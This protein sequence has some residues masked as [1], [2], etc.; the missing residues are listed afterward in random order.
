MDETN[1]PFEKEAFARKSQD[2]AGRSRRDRRSTKWDDEFLAEALTG[3][4]RSRLL[5]L[6]V[7]SI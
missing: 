6:D 1:E 4:L 2:K 5:F 3:H 7:D